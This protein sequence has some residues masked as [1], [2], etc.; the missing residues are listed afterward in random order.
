[1]SETAGARLVPYTEGVVG[2]IVSAFG[3]Y[4]AKNTLMLFD[5]IGAVC[6]SVGDALAQ[7]Q[8]VA[9]LMP[10]LLARFRAHADDDRN[11]WPVFECMGLVASSLRQAFLPYAQEVFF[12]CVTVCGHFFQCEQQA[13]AAQDDDERPNHGFLVCALDLMSS[14]AEA[15]GASV[16]SLVSQSNALA[17]LY[18]VRFFSC[19]IW[20]H[21]RLFQRPLVLSLIRTHFHLANIAIDLHSGGDSRLARRATIGF[22][23]ARRP[24]Q[25]VHWPRAAAH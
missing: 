18:Q 9:A 7:P 4:Q 11:L 25:A 2:G 12:R 14:T 3:V 16:E 15:I 1:M 19:L 20:C 23:A 24:R 13:A 22:C 17:L 8:L 6:D 21:S 10:P 5:L